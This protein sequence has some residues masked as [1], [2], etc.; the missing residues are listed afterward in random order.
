MAFF[1]FFQ[2]HHGAAGGRQIINME[3]AQTHSCVCIEPTQKVP[4]RKKTLNPVVVNSGKFRNIQRRL[5][6]EVVCTASSISGWTSVQFNGAHTHIEYLNIPACLASQ[7]HWY[8][9]SRLHTVSSPQPASRTW[10]NTKKRHPQS[11]PPQH[12]PLQT[13]AASSVDVST[14]SAAS[15]ASEL[16]GV[17]YG[18]QIV[19][20]GEA[21]L[22]FYK[23]LEST[24]AR[25]WSRVSGREQRLFFCGVISWV[26]W[27]E[28]WRAGGQLQKARWICWP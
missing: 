27:R 17:C 5:C 15:G 20:E 18:W 23:A 26:W 11:H 21:S 3:P 14:P 4:K 24:G 13:L 6:V 7:S 16:T 2:W 12:E 25:S 22:V 19:E 8:D 10:A 9:L 28:R 1:L